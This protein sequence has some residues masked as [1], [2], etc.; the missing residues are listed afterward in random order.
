MP[1]EVRCLTRAV[2]PVR[3]KL[4]RNTHSKKESNNERTSP[5]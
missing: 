1:C 3:A 2:Y 5:Q 4:D